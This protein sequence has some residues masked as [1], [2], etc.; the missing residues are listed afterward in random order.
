MFLLLVF[1]IMH[2]NNTAQL[3]TEVTAL[4]KLCMKTI[5]AATTFVQR[6]QGTRKQRFTVTHEQC[7]AP[8]LTGCPST[9]NRQKTLHKQIKLVML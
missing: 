1:L 2:K 5:N 7:S 6:F 4:S 9:V 3:P 8:R